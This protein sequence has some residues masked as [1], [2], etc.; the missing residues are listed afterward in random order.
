MNEKCVSGGENSETM[1]DV[2]DVL[3]FNIAYSRNVKAAQFDKT[4]E[5][6]SPEN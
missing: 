3:P 5:F 2:G 1:Q 6:E 4:K